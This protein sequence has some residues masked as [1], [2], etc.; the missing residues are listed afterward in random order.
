MSEIHV[1][2]QPI[3]AGTAITIC[4]TLDPGQDSME[5]E[6]TWTHEDGSKSKQTILIERLTEGDYQCFGTAIMPPNGTVQGIAHDT[7]GVAEDR[8]IT[9]TN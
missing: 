1:L 9:F 5:I 2:G 6:I 4:A 3:P 7:S 8:G